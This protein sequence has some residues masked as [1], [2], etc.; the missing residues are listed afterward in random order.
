MHKKASE[1]EVFFAFLNYPK[2]I[3]QNK[4]ISAGIKQR[5]Q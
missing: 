4:D 1:M 2:I 3:A 5:K